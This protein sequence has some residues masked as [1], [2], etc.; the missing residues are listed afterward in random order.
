MAESIPYNLLAEKFCQMAMPEPQKNEVFSAKTEKKVDPPLPPNSDLKIALVVLICLCL[1]I[2]SGYLIFTQ[3]IDSLLKQAFCGFL[4]AGGMGGLFSCLSGT[5]EFSFGKWGKATG[6]VAVALIVLVLVLR[7][8]GLWSPT[9][10]EVPQPGITN[11]SISVTQTRQ[12]PIWGRA[13]ASKDLRV[14]A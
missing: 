8:T 13:G 9:N 7:A 5:A 10:S 2:A 11:A 4:L 1:L 6:A 3:S 14:L 12:V